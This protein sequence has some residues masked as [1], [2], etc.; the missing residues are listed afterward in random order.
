MKNLRVDTSGESEEVSTERT[1]SLIRR[2]IEKIEQQLDLTD[3]KGS[4]GDYIKLLQ[5][6]KELEEKRF[7]RIEVKWVDDAD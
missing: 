2:L 6:Q 5:L 3:A 1:L 7:R 4:I